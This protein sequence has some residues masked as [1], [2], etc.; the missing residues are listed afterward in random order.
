MKKVV[1]VVLFLG[2]R[3][4]EREARAVMVNPKMLMLPD[5]YE[6]DFKEAPQKKFFYLEAYKI[7]FPLPK[8]SKQVNLTQNKLFNVKKNPQSHLHRTCCIIFD[9][10]I[11]LESRLEF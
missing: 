8:P 7:N 11:I 3:E 4:K 10:L 9:V 2:E 1:T 6:I 5:A